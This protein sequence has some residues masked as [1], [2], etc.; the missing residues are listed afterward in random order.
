MAEAAQHAHPARATLRALAAGGISLGLLLAPRPLLAEAPPTPAEASDPAPETASPSTEAPP[1]TEKAEGRDA[2]DD[3]PTEATD[4]TDGDDVTEDG[5][6]E[7]AAAPANKSATAEPLRPMQS[8]AWWTM[9][10]AFA[11]GTGAGVL[12]GLSERQEDRATRLSTL[13]DGS[14]GAQPLYADRKDEYEQYLSRGQAYANAAVGVGV[15]SGLATVTAITLFAID[16]RR[17][18]KERA[19][20][21]KQRAQVRPRLGGMEVRF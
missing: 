9:F 7:D 10:G 20:N 3:E 4:D 13:F 16:A 2:T 1:E 17:Q 11:V 21:S 19:P 14:T 5:D 8:A 6:D 18:R 12:A 15:V